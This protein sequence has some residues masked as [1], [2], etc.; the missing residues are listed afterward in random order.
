MQTRMLSAPAPGLGWRWALVAGLAALSPIALAKGKDGPGKPS[1]APRDR[2]A[3]AGRIALPAGHI[4]GLAPTRHFSSDYLYAEYDAGRKVSIIDVTSPGRPSVV[5]DFT[6]PANGAPD[7]IIAA[8]TSALA[9]GEQPSSATAAQPI[10][11]KIMSFS[12]VE[13]PQVLREFSGV[14]A[15]AR[16][17]SRGLIF[18]A[19]DGGIWILQELPAEDPAVEA[20]FAKRVIYDR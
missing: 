20:A 6:Y 10:S 14:T 8:G 19:D 4:T 16:D 1:L 12:D 11:V 5:G 9:I 17:D 15:I 3:V 18:L 13:H 7:R 2:I